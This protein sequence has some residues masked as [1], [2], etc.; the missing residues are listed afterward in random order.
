MTGALAALAGIFAQLSLLA[1]GGVNTVLPEMQRQVVRVHG[2]MTPAE[3]AALFALAQAAPGP[4]M[5]IST[6]IGWR[7]AG[8]P[9][10]LVATLSL[11]GPPSL[12]SY[13]VSRAWHRFHHA[14]WRAVVQRGLTPVTVGLVMAAATLL[15]EATS[16]DWAKGAVTAATAVL[17]LSTRVHPLILLGLGGALGAMGILR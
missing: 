3:F 13:T 16:G 4:N 15:T 17:L 9:G 5:L 10:A 2:W 14:P 8:V 11:C 6:L 1:I 7:V 12:L